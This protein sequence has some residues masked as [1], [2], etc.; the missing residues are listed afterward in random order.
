MFGFLG[1]ILIFIFIIILIGLSLI[2]GILRFIF[3]LGKRN[4]KHYNGQ[5]SQQTDDNPNSTASSS[6]SI[7]KKKIFSD[8]DGEYVDFEEVE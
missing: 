7:N 8:D 2:G 5:Q 1:F 6:S 3:G 4:P